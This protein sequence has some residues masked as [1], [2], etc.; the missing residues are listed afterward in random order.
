MY[1][2]K[3]IYLTKNRCNQC[4]MDH[5]SNTDSQEIRA[6]KERKLSAAFMQYLSSTGP[7]RG[8]PLDLSS[9]LLLTLFYFLLLTLFYFLFFTL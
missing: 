5:P 2:A 8:T 3:L 1:I 7:V 6:R 9:F 4:M